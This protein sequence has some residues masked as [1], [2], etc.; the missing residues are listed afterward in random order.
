MP[1]SYLSI[2]R[3]HYIEFWRETLLKLLAFGTTTLLVQC[4]WLLTNENSLISFLSQEPIEQTRTWLFVILTTLFWIAWYLTTHDCIEKRLHKFCGIKIRDDELLISKAFLMPRIK[5]L[6][7][8]GI[9]S[10]WYAAMDNWLF[11][12]HVVSR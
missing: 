12:V 4:G 10:A 11:C 9:A 5:F 7:I 2:E 8:V 6:T 1:E 3:R